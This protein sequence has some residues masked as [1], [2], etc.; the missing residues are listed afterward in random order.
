MSAVVIVQK[1]QRLL[2]MNGVV[3]PPVAPQPSVQTEKHNGE[4]KEE[5]GLDDEVES[6]PDCHV[7]EAVANEDEATEK[8]EINGVNSSEEQPE[9]NRGIKEEE[10]AADDDGVNDEEVGQEQQQGLDH[11]LHMAH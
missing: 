6:G 4:E 3:R 2:S 7:F 10:V 9:C 5:E 8:K 1:M 11:R